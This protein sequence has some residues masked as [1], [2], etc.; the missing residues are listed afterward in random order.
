MSIVPSRRHQLAIFFFLAYAITWCI[1]IPAYLF[2][3]E[4]DITF[5]NEASF[6][7][8]LSF[9]R[10]DL[11]RD[12]AFWL[13]L[14]LG[15]FG[16][17]LAG[18]LAT[19]M[20]KGASGL[21]DLFV[22]SVHIRIP[23]KWIVLTFAI[24]IGL[25]VTSLALGF[26]F[27]GFQPLE[28]SFLVP[29]SLMIPF[30][31][32]MIVFT[33]VAEEFGW[34]GYALPELQQM[35]SAEKSSWILGIFWGLWHIPSNLLMPYLRGEL[36]V[37]FAVTILLGLTFGIVGWTIVLTWI[38]NN[39]KSLFWIIVLH[40]FFNAA[41]SYLILSSG[42]QIAN[43]IAGILPWVVATYVLKKYGSQTLMKYGE[44]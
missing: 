16:P 2:A 11:P 42:N 34:R 40:G 12:V 19:A 22:R 35:Y 4:R 6:L 43:I 18:L 37:P 7:H 9:L 31:F 24:P 36:T 8:L 29:A 41:Q 1:Q 25:L 20:F 21:K 30:L 44:S 15:S 17:T 28:Y 26:V 38:Y 33:G 3:H 13:L 14:V 32:F 39:T 5:T 27:T 23:W 10:G